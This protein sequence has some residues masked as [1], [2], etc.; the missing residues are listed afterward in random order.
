MLLLPEPPPQDGAARAR[1]LDVGGLMAALRERRFWLLSGPAMMW[2]SMWFGLMTWLPRYARDTLGV[3]P[4]ATGLLPAAATAA[5]MPGSYA[6]GWAASRHPRLS[7]PL[8]FLAQVGS[9][10]AV[11]ALPLLGAQPS[12][13]LLYLVVLVVG[14]LFGAYFLYVPLLAS[15][16][17][18]R[19]VGTATG[20]ANCLTFLPSF[21]SPWLMGL[22]LDLVD[23][24]SVPDPVYS[25]AAYAA[26]WSVAAAFL[27]LGLAGAV[28]LLGWPAR[29]GR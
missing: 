18:A 8:F 12:Q 17:P 29:R 11:T 21:V 27:V 16:T 13:A 2:G 19:R 14:V 24:P 6:F 23:R 4:A 1:E 22:T 20:L 5:L 10:A 28:A 7:W 15:G 25:P 9:L 26:A 3:A